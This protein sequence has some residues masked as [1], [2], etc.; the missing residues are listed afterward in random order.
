MASRHCFGD[1]SRLDH[2]LITKYG[3]RIGWLPA[4]RHFSSLFGNPGQAH[5]VA[6]RRAPGAVGFG[7]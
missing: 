2:G 6:K 1:R 3:L 4:S 5:K 7:A